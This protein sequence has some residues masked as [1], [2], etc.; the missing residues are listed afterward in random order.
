M[1]DV[2][3]AEEEED[4]IVMR[5]PVLLGPMRDRVGSTC[6]LQYPLRPRWRPYELD[7]LSC[8]SIR[9]KQHQLEF[10]LEIPSAGDTD[11]EASSHTCKLSSTAAV[12]KTPY[13]MGLLRLEVSDDPAAAGDTPLS[14]LK[15]TLHLAPLDA[16]V[17]MRP[18]FSQIDEAGRNL[19]G[20]ENLPAPPPTA[21]KGSKGA[22]S[23]STAA[24]G[25]SAATGATETAGAVQAVFKRAETEQE[26][27]A[28]RL[29]HAYW[30]EQRESE[31]WRPL[32]L[33]EEADDETDGVRADTFGL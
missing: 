11:C 8:A 2:D 5:I 18:D 16:C 24:A 14:G 25:S 28:R 13:A 26:E 19:D 23:S 6:L 4:D 1:M 3:E 10:Q 30:M 31:P 12:H 32:K 9:A 21:K 17:Q 29:S 27:E 33:H 7:K 15:A 20:T 22:A